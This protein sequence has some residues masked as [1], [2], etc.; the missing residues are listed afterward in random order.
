MG[1]LVGHVFEFTSAK[2]QQESKSSSPAKP[3]AAE[4]AAEQYL[5]Q[6][7]G[8][9]ADRPES[10]YGLG[11]CYYTKLKPYPPVICGDRTPFDLWRYAGR[12]KSST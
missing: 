10:D 5:R 2:G 12:G 6:S 1:F 3:Y 9:K 7:P 11:D 4:Q 8:A